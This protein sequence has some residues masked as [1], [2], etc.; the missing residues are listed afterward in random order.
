MPSLEGKKAPAFALD[1]STGGKVRLKDLAGKWVVLYFYPKDATPGCTA[2]AQAFRDAKSAFEERG[3]VIL[4]VSKDSIA[5]HQKFAEKHGLDFALLSDP[6]GE[7]IEKYCAW[8]EKNMYGKK[9]MGILRTTVL[10]DPAG[11]VRRIWPKVR[12]KGHVEEVLAAL[13]ELAG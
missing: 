5:S 4:G 10:I 12:V 7:V 1:A 2:E 8:G 6:S 11:K 3:A 13:D 9:T